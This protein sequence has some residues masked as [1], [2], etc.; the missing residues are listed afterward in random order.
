M[1]ITCHRCKGTG[2]I[3][4]DDISSV[5]GNKLTCPR[6]EGSGKEMVDLNPRSSAS[7]F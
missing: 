5:M 1:K 7:E 2:W 6:C 3:I 4:E